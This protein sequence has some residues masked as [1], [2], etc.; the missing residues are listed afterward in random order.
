MQLARNPDVSV[1]MRGVMEKC[2]FCVQ[3]IEAA[4]IGQKVKAGQSAPTAVP[5]GTIKTAC[6]QAC[7]AEA[8]V[9]GNI[10]DPESAVSK[11]KKDPR[12][13]TTL[14]FLNTRPRLT[15][16]ARVRNPNEKMPD[17]YDMPNTAQA[18]FGDEHS[19]GGGHGAAEPAHGAEKKG[20]H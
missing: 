3:R 17:K 8:I 4:K 6:Q 11:A 13:Y 12:D 1:R 14:E 7:P 5:D 19:S 20:A 10:N 15:Y 9:F 2:T 16:L 18:Y